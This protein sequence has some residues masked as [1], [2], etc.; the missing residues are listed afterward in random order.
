M[1]ANKVKFVDLN[2]GKYVSKSKYDDDLAAKDKQLETL[3][4]TISSRDGDLEDLKQ[5][6]LNAGTD[7]EKLS[8]IS[9]DM[10]KLQDQYADDVKS[11]EEKL[12]KQ[13][14][15]FAVKEFASTKKFS[16]NAA[17]RDFI[18]SMIAKELKMDNDSILG[19]E[20][21]VTAYS[22][23]NEDAFIVEAPTPTPEPPKPTFVSPTPG[24]NPAPIDSNAFANAFAFSGVRKHE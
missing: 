3:N 19:A 9:A 2:E 8:T 7:A 1:K 12:R 17:K 24:G 5:Q 10:Q 20:D 22:A 11:Y 6:L 13:A 15:E 23:N 18:Q 4:E 16:S 14:Y 21:F